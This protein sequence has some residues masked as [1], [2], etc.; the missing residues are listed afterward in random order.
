M[1]LIENE[2]SKQEL[3][4]LSGNHFEDFVKAVIDIENEVIVID[5]DLHSDEEAYLLDMGSKQNSLW[6]LNLYP[7]KPQ[8]NFIEFDSMINLRPRDENRSRGVDNPEIRGIIIRI[9][10]KLI[11]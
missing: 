1:Q 11:K 10:G 3:I 4:N 6:G 7:N 2:I 5:A 8:E 9:V